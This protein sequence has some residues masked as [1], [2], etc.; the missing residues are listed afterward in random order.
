MNENLAILLAVILAGMVAMCWPAIT[1]KRR[2][3]HRLEQEKLHAL[4]AKAVLLEEMVTKLESMVPPPNR[5]VPREA[6]DDTETYEIRNGS[7]D[8][9]RTVGGKQW[10]QPGFSQPE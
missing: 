6:L 4:A 7:G 1:H 10:E 9:I 3:R 8:V 2:E 5:P